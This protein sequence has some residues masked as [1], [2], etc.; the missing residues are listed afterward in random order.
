MKVFIGPYKNWF[1]PY[2]LAEALCFWVKKVPDEHGFLQ[3]PEWV[4]NF[5]TWLA[6]GSNY[7][8][9]DERH[10][11][12]SSEHETWL[13]KFLQWIDKKRTR[14]IYVKIDKYDTWNMDTTLTLIILPM[15]KQ[16][17]ETKHGSQIIDDEDV[18]EK[19]RTSYEPH[20]YE[21][22]DLFPEKKEVTDEAADDLVHMRWE[23]VLNEM[24]WAFEQLNDEN[25]DAQFHSGVHDMRSV[26]SEW[27]ENGKPKFY[28]LVT[29]PNDTHV[30]DREGH[31]K[32]TKRID[33]GLMLFGKYFRGLWD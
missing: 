29:G 8:K 1:G 2:Q 22:L 26:I 23:Y 11:F 7:K 3:K 15:L 33:N 6:H 27:D 12:A 19:L 16:L 14:K 21:Q 9:P 25:N 30:Y 5:G 13:Y 10:L 31:L 4:F 17:K 28:E 18:P 24:I 20:N 32:H